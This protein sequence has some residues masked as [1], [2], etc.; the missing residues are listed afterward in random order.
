MT[1]VIVEMDSSLESN[2]E[3]VT[4]N[5]ELLFNGIKKIGKTERLVKGLYVIK[6]KLRIC[7]VLKIKSRKRI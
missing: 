3:F 4:K 1:D 6:L 2:R 5:R 7:F